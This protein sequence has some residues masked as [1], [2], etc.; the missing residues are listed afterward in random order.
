MEQ[1][2]SLK[3]TKQQILDAYNDLLSKIKEKKAEE[4]KKVQ[5]MKRNE[6]TLKKAADLSGEGIMKDLTNLKS[7][8]STTLDTLSDK[9][10]TRYKTFEE[11]EEAI[12]LEKKN[13]EEMYQLTA[14]TDSLAAML[15]AQKE[16]KREF[17]MSM[18]EQKQAFE[19]LMK[20]RKADFEKEMAEQKA[21]WTKLKQNTETTEAEAA[22]KRKKERERE[23]EEYQYALKLSRKKD[24]DLYEEKK[25]KLEKELEEKR[26][27]FEKEFAQREELIKRSEAEL[28]DLRMKSENF[29]AEME[30]AVQTAIKDTTEKLQMQYD[31]NKELVE[32]QH[33]GEVKLKDQIIQ[34]LQVKVKDLE[35]QLKE[36]SQKTTNAEITVKDI[37]I[38]AIESSSKPHY[39]DKF[40]ETS[41]K[42]E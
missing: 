18:Q 9:L 23:E 13:L 10:L 31:F 22:D 21:A 38:K 19:S 2:I 16:T 33:Q 25:Q 40:R 1:E 26:L 17:E 11:L 34:T 27:L 7:N 8:I 30:N 24:T 41:E 35:A 29:P 28:Q 15:N 14:E 3:N 6:V 5:E 4:P 36:S 42:K 20:E 12:Q 37:A 32:K 39:I